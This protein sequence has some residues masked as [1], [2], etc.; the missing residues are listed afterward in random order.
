MREPTA[1]STAVSKGLELKV[2]TALSAVQFKLF[3][4]QG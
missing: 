4:A 2:G 3:V 1:T